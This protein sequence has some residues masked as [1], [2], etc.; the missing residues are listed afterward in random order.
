MPRIRDAQA[1]HD[2]DLS[3]VFR[4]SIDGLFGACEQTC[5]TTDIYNVRSTR[6]SREDKERA[7]SNGLNWSAI[8][9][10][11]KID[12]HN[13]TSRAEIE[14]RMQCPPVSS[15]K[16]SKM[17]IISLVGAQA[18]TNSSS[19]YDWRSKSH[20]I[21]IDPPSIKFFPARLLQDTDPMWTDCH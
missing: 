5:H 19:S 10:I 6:T 17:Y 8:W 11:R 16:K 4:V 9:H 3:S 14:F 7:I 15:E 20:C 12:F 13:L 21:S 18:S 1:A 2:A